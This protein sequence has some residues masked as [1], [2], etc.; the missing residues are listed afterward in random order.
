MKVVM[1]QISA[2]VYDCE[3]EDNHQE[4]SLGLE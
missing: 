2:E 4:E 3:I 1:V